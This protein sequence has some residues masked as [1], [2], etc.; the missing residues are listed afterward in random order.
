MDP[1]SEV[2][3]TKIIAAAKV[4]FAKKGFQ[5][6]NIR[7]IGG[8]AGA[9]LGWVIQLFKSKE[10]LFIALTEPAATAFETCFGDQLF[11]GDFPNTLNTGIEALLDAAF[12]DP[13]SMR[14]LSNANGSPREKFLRE[15]AEKCAQNAESKYAVD[16]AHLTMLFCI[17]FN[18]LMEITVQGMTRA[19]AKAFL[20]VLCSFI[21]AGW[22]KA[23]KAN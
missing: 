13:D 11:E 18:A 14:L 6:A 19:S 22:E 1:K 12:D 4:E 7:E 10:G 3:K 21:V 20:P 5:E 17:T 2:K 8:A 23:L 9:T 15:L 16:P